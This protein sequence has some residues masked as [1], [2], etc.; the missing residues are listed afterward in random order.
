M[1][2]SGHCTARIRPASMPGLPPPAT[3]CTRPSA[4]ICWPAGRTT[5]AAR[6]REDRADLARGHRGA[7]A[8][9]HGLGGLRQTRPRLAVRRG[10]PAFRAVLAEVAPGAPWPG[11]RRKDVV[12]VS[13]AVPGVGGNDDVLG[14]RLG[15]GHLPGKRLTTVLRP[16]DPAG[17]HV[18]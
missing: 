6:G 11:C 3:T 16:R 13:S 2:P 14:R 5:P 10:G 17:G 8:T 4:I 18:M 12:R 7:K 1:R 15:A 9:S